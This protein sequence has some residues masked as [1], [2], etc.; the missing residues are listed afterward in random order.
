MMNG[1]LMRHVVSTRL[2]SASVDG[3]EGNATAGAGQ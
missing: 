1:N 2:W 3:Q